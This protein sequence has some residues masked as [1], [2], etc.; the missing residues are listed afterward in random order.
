MNQATKQNSLQTYQVVVYDRALHPELFELRKR[1][2]IEH[3]GYELESWIMPGGHALRFEHDGACITELVTDQENKLPDTG[4]VAA[5][6]CA[7]ERDFDTSFDR[8]KMGYMTTVQ[9]EQLSENLF[10]AT[11]EEMLDYAGEVD[12]LTH[13]WDE[14]SG[15]GLSVL[16]VQR[17]SKEMHVQSYHL[18]PAGG[19]VL[20]TQTI[21]E[22]K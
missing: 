9:T 19:I 1:R 20:R 8:V 2:S 21:F 10:I 4:V 12:A 13:Q 22:H 16:D 18:I 14:E 15:S 6:L 5:F 11:F 3:G 7:G 17:F